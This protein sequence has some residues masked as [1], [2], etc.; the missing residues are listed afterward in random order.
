[1]PQECD[2]LPEIL[3][4]SYEAVVY[5]LAP[6]MEGRKGGPGRKVRNYI[7]ELR[8]F[9][10]HQVSDRAVSH[11]QKQAA[12]GNPFFPYLP[13][14]LPHNPPPAQPDFVKQG[15]SQSK[16]IGHD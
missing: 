5:P 15:R 14:T 16:E 9:I 7:D 13:D 12:A 10:D 1:M 2:E 4:P 6:V 3:Q 8:P 11:D